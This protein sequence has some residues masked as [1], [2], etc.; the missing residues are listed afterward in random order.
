M[1]GPFVG[2]VRARLDLDSDELASASQWA[3]RL[4]VSTESVELY[5]SSDVI[6]LHLDSFIWPRIIHYDLN[7]SHTGSPWG[8]RFAGQADVPRVVSA[9]VTGAMWS[10]TTNPFRAADRRRD[11][12]EINLAWIRSVLGATT[13]VS[14]VSTAAEYRRAREAGRHGAF[15]SIQGANAL[16]ADD[17]AIDLAISGGVSR[18]TLVHLTNSRLGASSSPLSKFGRARGLTDFGRSMVER[19]DASRVIVDLAHISRP[20]FWDA[21]TAH[22]ASVPLM[23]THTGVDAVRSHWRNVDDAQVRAI[24]ETGGCIGIMLE[25]SFLGRSPVAVDVVVDHLEHLVR[26]GG[27]A[28]AAIGTDFDG[29][30]TP[31]VSLSRHAH[32]PRLVESMR[33]RGWGDER[34]R[35]VL[36]GNALRVIESVR[37]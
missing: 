8:R 6:D 24:S 7:R 29:M 36:G 12:F 22:D 21:V 30:I 15:I 28:V 10:I 4:G 27:E 31:P 13:D 26:V 17:A 16:S 25:E 33:G 9:G 5:R 32:L 35:A 37:G 11:A 2:S 18:V 3:R 34:I 19:L 14:I 20:G 23:V 1:T